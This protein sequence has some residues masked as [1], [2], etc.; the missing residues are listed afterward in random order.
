MGKKWREE[1]GVGT[2]H[3]DLNLLVIYMWMWHEQEKEKLQ[4]PHFFSVFFA[5]NQG[6]YSLWSEILVNYDQILLVYLFTS[7]SK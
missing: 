5:A 1:E 2:S 6:A 7:G 4:G 3:V